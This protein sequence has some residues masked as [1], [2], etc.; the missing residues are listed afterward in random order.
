MI[1][2]RMLRQHFAKCKVTRTVLISAVGEKMFTFQIEKC[3]HPIVHR[4]ASMT[5]LFT[6]YK[7]RRH[8]S[9]KITELQPIIKNNNN[10]IMSSKEF[11]LVSSEQSGTLYFTRK[12]MQLIRGTCMQHASASERER[13]SNSLLKYILRGSHGTPAVATEQ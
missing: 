13:H 2:E 1:Y 12:K 8:Q 10:D 5:D 3:C 7:R 4:I 11:L 9:W 6:F